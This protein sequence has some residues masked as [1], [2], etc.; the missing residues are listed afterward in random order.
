MN[1]E[2]TSLTNAK[3][4]LT[5]RIRNLRE[6]SMSAI[7]ARQNAKRNTKDKNYKRSIQVQIN[8]MRERMRREI[9]SLQSQKRNYTEQIK[10]ARRR[11]RR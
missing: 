4:N 8:D 2:V 9:D 1:S 10:A 7:K 3:H 5:S 11:A 6:S